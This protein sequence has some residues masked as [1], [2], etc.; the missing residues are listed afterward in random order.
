[1]NSVTV[2][3][4][5]VLL[6]L[7]AI[8]TVASQIYIR[9]HQQYQTQTAAASSSATMQSFYGV[10]VRDEKPIMYTGT[11]A[12]SYPMPDGGKAANGSVVAYIYSS[13]EDIINNGRIE[14]LKKEI[15]LLES[16]QSPGTTEVAQPE[17]LSSLIEE[18]YQT[19]STDLAKKDLS[20]LSS[21][22]DSFLSLMCIYQITIG[23]AANFN[24]RI[25]ELYRTLNELEGRRKAP[26]REIT[27]DS[28][29]YFVSY[30]DGYETTLNTENISELTADDIKQIIA[31]ENS[32]KSKKSDKSIGKLI[33]GYGWKM[34]GIIDN[35]EATFSPGDPVKLKFASTSDSVTAVVERIT[36]TDDPNESIVQLDCEEM[37]FDLVKHRVEHVEMILHDY[38]GIKVPR[39]ALRFDKDNNKGVYVLL[40]QRVMFKKLDVIF[41]CSDY[42]LSRITADP[43]Y[44]NIYDEIIISGVDTAEY[45]LT[46]ETEES[47][48]DEEEPDEEEIPVYSTTEEPPEDDDDT[49]GEN[50]EDDGEDGEDG[51]EESGDGA[52]SN[53]NEASE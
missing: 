9:V 15:S 38:E 40:G 39:E 48:P 51:D 31:D 45:I 53:E 13:E 10:F 12:V 34:V 19:I 44:L 3:V 20:R 35:S 4:L 22:R 30:T 16:A 49:D 52:D 5:T 24:G 23:D 50:G 28:T 7:F 33:D 43:E 41:E 11:G 1:M 6:S 32:D 2:R 18:N 47:P 21:E 27:A 46:N 37:T 26:Q 25:D 17:F 36:E 29:G 14:E 8:I 42:L